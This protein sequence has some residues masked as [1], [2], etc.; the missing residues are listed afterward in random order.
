[1]SRV[2]LAV[3]LAKTLVLGVIGKLSNHFFIPAMLIGTIELCRF[4][5]LSLTL[6]LPGSHKVIAKQNLLPSFSR[7][8]FIRSR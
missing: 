8:L 6:T 7:T 2:R 5:Q 4:I 3:R 1:M